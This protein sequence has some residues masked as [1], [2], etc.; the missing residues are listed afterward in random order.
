MYA[1][2]FSRS[3]AY[4]KNP[5][6]GGFFFDLET[7]EPLING[8]GFVEAL[9]DWVK[10]PNMSHPAGSILVWVMKLIPLVRALFSFSWDDAFVA[11]MQDDVQSKT[12]LVLHRYR[13]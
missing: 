13:V 6:L 1:A 4:S 9:T 2:F 8:P 7:M 12:R 10:L 11:A 3:V 5:K